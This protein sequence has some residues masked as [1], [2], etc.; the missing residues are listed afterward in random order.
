MTWETTLKN[1]DQAKAK[2]LVEGLSKIRK[3]HGED[4]EKFAG[5]LEYPQDSVWRM[6]AVNRH[7]VRVLVEIKILALSGKTLFKF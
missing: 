1:N 3:E 4:F 7:F 6:D 2:E 5:Y